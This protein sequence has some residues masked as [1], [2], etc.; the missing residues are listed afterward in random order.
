MPVDKSIPMTWYGQ[1]LAIVAIGA[2]FFAI[3]LMRF[4]HNIALS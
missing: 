3:A 2:T 1:L 4:R